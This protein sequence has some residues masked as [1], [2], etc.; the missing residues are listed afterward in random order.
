[1]KKKPLIKDEGFTDP[2]KISI[3]D[4]IPYLVEGTPNPDVSSD[5]KRFM[6]YVQGPD[7]DLYTFETRKVKDILIQFYEVPETSISSP[8][9]VASFLPP[10]TGLKL[11]MASPTDYAKVAISIDFPEYL[12]NGNAFSEKYFGNRFGLHFLPTP[13]KP[14]LPTMKPLWDVF[15]AE[16][17]TVCCYQGWE[18]FQ[19]SSE[20][21]V[22]HQSILVSPIEQHYHFMADRLMRIADWLTE[23][24]GY[25]F[26]E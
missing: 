5:A 4:I 25:T 6:E 14:T 11:S 18:N 10:V 7:E 16:L 19:G 20:N 22:I 15:Y 26:S 2:S 21:R 17:P 8:I 24:Y 23:S 12:K 3:T 1:M 13:D 9:L